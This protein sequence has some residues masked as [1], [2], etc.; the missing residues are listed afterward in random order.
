MY[1]NPVTWDQWNWPFWCPC[2]FR[3]IICSYWHQ[4]LE[5]IRDI[6]VNGDFILHPFKQKSYINFLCKMAKIMDL[7]KCQ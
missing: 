4:F 6:S 7:E 3:N 1:S 5:L 2:V